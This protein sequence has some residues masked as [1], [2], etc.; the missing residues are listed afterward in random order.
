MRVLICHSR[1]LSGPASG[2]N[3][4]VADEAELLSSAG[5]QVGLFTPEPATDSRIGNLQLGLGAIYSPQ[6]RRQIRRA[7]AAVRPDVVHLHNLFPMLSP[8]VVEAATKAGVPVVMTLHNYRLMCLPANLLRDGRPCEDCVGRSVL[9]P[10]VVHSCYRDSLA[11]SA[12]LASSLSLHNRLGTFGLVAQF[13]AVSEFVRRKHVE[14]GFS[15]ARISVRHNFAWPGDPR[16]G[17]GDYFLFAGRLSA[18]KNLDSVLQAW[19]GTKARLIV[20]GDGPE[21]NR[22]QA[23]RPPGVEFRGGVEPD[24]VGKLLSHAR[25]LLLPSISYEGAPRTIVE[26][27][28]H[29]VPVIASNIGSI[30]EF[31]VPEETGVLVAP[32]DQQAWR[33]SI[34]KLLDDTESQRLG[35]GAFAAWERR[36]TPEIGLKELEA[37]YRATQ[38]LPN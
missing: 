17:P 32:R 30:P 8:A 5:H 3:R 16:K 18:E 20:V 19:T 25:A 23:L 28:A 26:A 4:V 31:V 37:A 29:G 2:E 22:L 15:S 10:G 27:Y 33:G 14:H 13:L 12:A 38:E 1:Y 6:G 9:W 35:A 7:I 24:E 36:F 21:A 34:S 11:G